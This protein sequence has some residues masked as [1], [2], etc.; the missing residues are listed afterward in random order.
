[1]TY[2]E[3]AYKGWH[4]S[5][6]DLAG[7]NRISMDSS[8]TFKVEDD[9]GNHLNGPASVES[10]QASHAPPMNEQ[11]PVV[12][13]VIDILQQISL[14]L[15]RA[16]QPAAVT[17]QRSTIERMAR[18]RPID[19]MGKKDDELSMAENWLERTERMLVQMHCTTEEKLEY[20]ISLPQDEAY[21]WWV[22]VTRTAD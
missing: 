6:A 15:Q 13:G 8:A 12:G 9:Q 14:T 11:E 21:Q 2:I 18:Y 16:A 3:F 10:G 17:T 20:A 19:F 1:M 22:S 4:D 7:L 5:D